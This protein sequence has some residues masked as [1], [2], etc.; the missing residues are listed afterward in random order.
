MTE[1]HFIQPRFTTEMPLFQ[2]LEPQVWSRRLAFG[3]FVL[4]KHISQS[5]KEVPMPL[6]TADRP[7]HD[8]SAT[9]ICAAAYCCCLMI[10]LG[11]TAVLSNSIHT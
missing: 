11:V 1:L 8:P 5:A 7:T 10:H 9:C 2:V 3:V 4:I 6:L